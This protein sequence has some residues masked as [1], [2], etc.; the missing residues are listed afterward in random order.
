MSLFGGGSRGVRRSDA[1]QSTARNTTSAGFHS[2]GLL[3]QLA[4]ADA[5]GSGDGGAEMGS[6]DE[7]S[8]IWTP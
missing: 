2:E 8:V 4:R 7:G 3:R 5:G 1:P 6:A